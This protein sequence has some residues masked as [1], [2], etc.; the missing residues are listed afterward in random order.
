MPRG[1]KWHFVSNY[2]IDS[3]G[4]SESFRMYVARDSKGIFYYQGVGDE[5]LTESFNC[6]E[7]FVAFF[8]DYYGDETLY[9]LRDTVR[10]IKGYENVVRMI[11]FRLKSSADIP[12]A[13]A[14]KT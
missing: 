6:P 10:S 7:F 2:F 4:C 3:M 1:C 14:S 12:V 5:T 9:E 11:D 13:S 8:A